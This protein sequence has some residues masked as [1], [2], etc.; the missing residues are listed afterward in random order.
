MSSLTCRSF[1]EKQESMSQ[2]SWAVK[3][4]SSRAEQKTGLVISLAACMTHG[5]LK[6][7][8][9]LPDAAKLRNQVIIQSLHRNMY[10]YNLQFTGAQIVEIGTKE[11]TSKEDLERAITDKTAA[12]FYVVFD[13]QDGVLPLEEVSKIAHSRGVPVI[14]D[15]AAELPPVENLK[16][17]SAKGSGHR[18]I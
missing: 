12:V 5:S 8:S 1:K 14:A 18:G 9:M 17:N 11:K 16:L 4:R 3:T 7:M 6:E 15:A 10:D 2:G 13:P